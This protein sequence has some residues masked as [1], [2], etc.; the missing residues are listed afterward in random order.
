MF[1]YKSFVKWL[2]AVVTGALALGLAFIAHN[3]GVL[4]PKSITTDPV[5]AAVV[6]VVLAAL[7]R[8]VNWVIG[9]LPA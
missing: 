9:K 4:D 8:G 2:S 3:L 6:G 7:Q 5:V 1:D